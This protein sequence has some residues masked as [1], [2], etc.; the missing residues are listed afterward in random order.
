MCNCLVLAIMPTI[1][2]ERTA[3][4]YRVRVRVIIT[5][6]SRNGGHGGPPEWR[7]Q[8]VSRFSAAHLIVCELTSIHD[9]ICL[10]HQ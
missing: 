5:V 6:I 8:I 7:T 4:D 10:P 2:I 1:A 3:L 9:D